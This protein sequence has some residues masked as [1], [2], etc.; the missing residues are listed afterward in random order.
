MLPLKDFFSIRIHYVSVPTRQ[1]KEHRG[2]ARYDP[3][4]LCVSLLPD[5]IFSISPSRHE[6]KAALSQLSISVHTHLP[7]SAFSA[8]TSNI[9]ADGEQQEPPGHAP[10]A[11]SK[12]KEQL[13]STAPRCCET[14]GQQMAFTSLNLHV[15]PPLRTDF[16]CKVP[17][18]HKRPQHSLALSVTQW[19]FPSASWLPRTGSCTTP[20]VWLG[21]PQLSVFVLNICIYSWGCR[22]SAP[23]TFALNLEL[24]EASL[25]NF[26]FNNLVFL[27]S[28]M[29]KNLM[30]ELNKL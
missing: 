26:F 6:Q 14:W 13:G 19:W 28:V 1:P 29:H 5:I 30:K 2:T 4:A 22:F 18:A 12:I 3:R 16:K 9:A 11:W 25:N 21:T 7:G 27:L 24:L 23:L 17:A 15:K 8:G 10:L 20:R